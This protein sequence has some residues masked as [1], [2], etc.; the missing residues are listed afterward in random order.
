[1]SASWGLNEPSGEL[2]MSR[3]FVPSKALDSTVTVK[4]FT[5]FANVR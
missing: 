1:M 3:A 2:S 5:G 4:R